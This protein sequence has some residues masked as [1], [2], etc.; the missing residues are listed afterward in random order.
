MEDKA[1][2]LITQ[3]YSEMKQQFEDMNKQFEDMN[4]QFKEVNRKLDQKADKTDIV[5]LENE[6]NPKVQ[7]LFDGYKQHTDILERI[8][9]E[10]T[11]QEEIIMR[12]IK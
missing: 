5:R 2:E 11:R 10:V 7:A 3:M 8:E 6:L 12:R 4:K 1:F 9:N